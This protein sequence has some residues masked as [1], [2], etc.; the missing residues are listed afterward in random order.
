MLIGYYFKNLSIFF[1]FIYIVSDSVY[2]EYLPYAYA[3]LALEKQNSYLIF[4]NFNLNTFLED[5]YN[6]VLVSIFSDFS[7]YCYFVFGIFF[8]LI[9]TVISYLYLMHLGLYG[10]FMLNLISIF[11]MWLCF[12][13]T[14]MD[15]LTND[16]YYYIELFNWMYLNSNYRVNFSFYVDFVSISFSFLTTT[17]ALFVYVYTFAYFRY[18]PLVERLILFL[19]SFIL[20]MVVLVSSGNMIVL[21]LGWEMIGMTSFFLINFWSSRIGT[22]KAAFKAYSF[23]KLSDAFIFLSILLIF[24]TCYSLDI[25]V[26]LNSIHLYSQYTINFGY[27]SFNFI[28]ILAYSFIGAAFIKSAQFGAHIWLP[29][30]MEA[31]VPASALIHS[32]TLVSA[33]I[34][35]LLRFSPI[36]QMSVNSFYII[37]FFGAFTAFYGG[38]VSSFQSDLKKILA[39][40]TISHCGFLMVVYTSFIPEYTILYLY[41]HGFFKATVFLSV[42]NVIRFNRNIQDFRK[43]GGYYKYLPFDSIMCF[44]C[45]INLCGLPFTYG[46]YI[47]HLLFV[48]LSQY[49]LFYFILWSLLFVGAVIGLFYSFRLYYYTFFDIKKGKKAHYIQSNRKVLNSEFYSNTSLLGNISILSLFIASY[50]FS[51]ILFYNMLNVN[52]NSGLLVDGEYNITFFNYFIEFKTLFL[53]GSFLNTIVIFLMLTIIFSTW[54][55]N[56]NYWSSINFLFLFVTFLIIFSTIILIINYIILFICYTI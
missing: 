52:T 44:L 7:V 37:S 22:L 14:F 41:I 27:I 1:T 48:G 9:T 38:W 31:P 11:V 3:E 24:N 21:F 16:T 53:N 8:F 40:S 29:D 5:L 32:A 34:Y 56:L 2:Y 46:Y 19:N 4:V 50:I 23:N 30:S 55:L 20:S 51:Y 49:K 39:Y 18:E 25:P 12:I 36:F 42:G 6:D 15:I 10:V 13:F 43:M 28:D 33:G 26:I 35:L 54:R 47:K 45:L 17:I